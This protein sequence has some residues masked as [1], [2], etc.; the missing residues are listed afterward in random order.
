MGNLVSECNRCTVLTDCDLCHSLV[1]TRANEYVQPEVTARRQPAA[2]LAAARHEQYQP[3][4]LSE[5]ELVQQALRL[6]QLE[7]LQRGGPGAA[8]AG[9][10][11]AGGTSRAEAQAA[12]QED[13]VERARLRDEQH[14]EYEESLRIDRE[15]AA[16][17]ALREKEEE[18]Q[19]RREAEEQRSREM[20]AEAELKAKEDRVS[21]ILD[22]AQQMLPP[23]PPES[24]DGRLQVLI[25]TPDGRRL[26]RAFSLQNS[27]GQVYA[28]AN[29]EGGEVLASRDYMLVANMPRRTY[30]D[31][32][33]S[34]K[35]AGL[36]GQCA[37]LVEFL[38]DD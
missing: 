4:N 25:R 28:F 9:S 34:L 37:L 33:A 18:E 27:I 36:Q 11:I 31:R 3:P 10:L 12:E 20:Q 1:A 19:K 15:R 16:E 17:K 14:A 21:K 13:A 32:S 24:E 38:D 8:A 22:E 30:E 26:K 35:E 5:A 2:N 7:A 23:E 6:S 29:V